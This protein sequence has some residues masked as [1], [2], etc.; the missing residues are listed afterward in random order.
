MSNKQ[1][2]NR[3]ATKQ[4]CWQLNTPDSSPHPQMIARVRKRTFD[5]CRHVVKDPC[6]RRLGRGVGADLRVALAVCIQLINLNAKFINFHTNPSIFIQNPS[7][8]INFHTNRHH[9]GRRR[10]AVLVVHLRGAVDVV[11]S[12]HRVAWHQPAPC[13]RERDLSITG[14]YIHYMNDSPDQ[15]APCFA[16]PQPPSVVV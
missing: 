9:H 4:Q 1:C 5:H 15:P 10:V 13:F 8:F 3:R 16:L 6:L 12:I 14:M 2:C 11:W 7:I